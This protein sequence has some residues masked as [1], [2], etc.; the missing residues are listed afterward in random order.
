M[1]HL[2]LLVV[3]TTIVVFAGCEDSLKPDTPPINGGE[4]SSQVTTP[5]PP[6]KVKGIHFR[7]HENVQGIYVISGPHQYHKEVSSSVESLPVEGEYSV[8]FTNA[9]MNENICEIDGKRSIYMGAS[10]IS[11]P[12]KD[13]TIMVPIRQVTCK[14]EITS[15]DNVKIL[16]RY[17]KGLVT[18][19]LIDG[20]TYKD[21]SFKEIG[22]SYYPYAGE[23]ELSAFVEVY[24]EGK[25]CGSSQLKKD[26]VLDSGKHYV[27]KIEEDGISISLSK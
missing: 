1:R 15:A 22:S 7:N 9:Q 11:T 3:L 6:P 24:K 2:N 27:A 12:L 21:P 13:T 18:S 8:F 25:L 5:N 23:M 16:N 14:L 20:E 17:I 26:I 19:V 10:S 4:D